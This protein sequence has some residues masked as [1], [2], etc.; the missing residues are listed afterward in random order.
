MPRKKF[1]DMFKKKSL[2]AK[3]YVPLLLQVHTDA[4]LLMN[5]T[6]FPLTVSTAA[7]GHPRG[8]W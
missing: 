1:S 6:V 2:T 4:V 3:E 8:C 5:A 7:E